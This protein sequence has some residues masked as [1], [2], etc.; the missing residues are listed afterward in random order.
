M[1]INYEAFFD[2]RLV[3]TQ[4]KDIWGLQLIKTWTRIK[5]EMYLMHIFTHLRGIY[6]IKAGVCVRTLQCTNVTSPP[7]LK[8]L[9]SQGYPWLPYDLTKVIKLIKETF[10][11]IF[12]QKN[13]L[14]HSFRIIVNPSVLLSGLVSLLPD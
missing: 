14:C 3:I 9:D 4:K 13:T 6:I 2:N 5:S 12:F 10:A 1:S 7:V 8:L 11:P